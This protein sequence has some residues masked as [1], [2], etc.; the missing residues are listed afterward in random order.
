MQSSLVAGVFRVVSTVLLAVQ[1]AFLT[2]SISLAEYGVWASLS[3]IGSLSMLGVGVGMQICNQ[4]SESGPAREKAAGGKETLFLAAFSVLAWLS[5][6][7][8]AAVL[9]LQRFIPWQLL[10]PGNDPRL[11][12]IARA[13]FPVCLAV[14]LLGL[15][16][17]IGS[18]GFRAFQENNMAAVVGP[19]AAAGSLVFLLFFIRSGKLQMV[20]LAPFLAW[21][22]VFCASFFLLLRKR[23]W[24]FR[25]LSFQKSWSLF[26]PFLK[27]SLRFSAFVLAFSLLTVNLPYYAGLAQG[28]QSAGRLD[29][30]FKVYLVLLAAIADMLQPLW[31]AYSSFGSRREYDLIRRSLRI[32]IA[33]SALL[34]LGASILVRMVGPWLIR[35]VTGRAIRID[36]AS[37]LLLSLWLLLCSLAH[38]LQVFLNARNVVRP[39][40]IAAVAILLP[41]P[42]L[43]RRAGAIGWRNGP[44]MIN[45]LGIAVVLAIMARK[46]F[47]E[48]AA[49]RVVI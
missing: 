37:F 8:V 28:F 42:L 34:A 21:S 39:Q 7:A 26:S 12:G 41:L 33:A 11:F 3:I 10:I 36:N 6:A 15:P 29:L 47:R 46:T 19:A 2:R 25:L 30:Y 20:Y 44:V 1:I 9:I 4:L 38:A 23:G 24:R 16:F 40:L 31:P 17:V 32:S 48:L 22:L 45:L 43:C 27:R 49:D 35:S 5:L 14:Q 13:A 18:F